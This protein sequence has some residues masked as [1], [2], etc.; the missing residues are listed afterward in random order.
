ML[1]KWEK[2]DGN[3]VK[4]DIEVAAP[5]VDRALDRAYRIIVKKVNLPGFRKGKVPRK[6]LESRFGP[7]VLH[8]EALEIFA[9]RCRQAIETELE[10]IVSPNLMFLPEA[11]TAPFLGHGG[12]ASHGSW[13]HKGLEIEQR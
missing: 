6:I 10:P 8:E 11:E 5:E 3:K 7:E 12:S 4:L 2:I 13:A 1:T 9:A